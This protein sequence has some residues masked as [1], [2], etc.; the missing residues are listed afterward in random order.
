MSLNRVT[1][2]VFLAVATVAGFSFLL[3]TGPGC[4]L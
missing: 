2:F 4:G 1:K 3:L